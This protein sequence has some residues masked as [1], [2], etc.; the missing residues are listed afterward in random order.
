MAAETVRYMRHAGNSFDRQYAKFQRPVGSYRDEPDAE[1]ELRVRLS[2]AIIDYHA[3]RLTRQLAGT[4]DVAGTPGEP[5]TI[6]RAD[7]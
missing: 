3:E 4:P 5:A 7:Q 1:F 2:Q 6:S